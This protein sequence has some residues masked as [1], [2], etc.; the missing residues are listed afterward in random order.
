MPDESISLPTPEQIATIVADAQAAIALLN[1]L[2]AL[3]ALIKA[4]NVGGVVSEFKSALGTLL[5]AH[6]GT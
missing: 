2:A 4:H 5:A 1:E 3:V 6:A